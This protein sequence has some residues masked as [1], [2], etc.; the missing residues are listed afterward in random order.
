MLEMV[1]VLTQRETIELDS[2]KLVDLYRQLGDAAAEDV[3]CRAMEELALRLAHTE[4]LYRRHQRQE[5]RKSARLIVAIAEQVGMQLLAK[6]AIDVTVCIDHGDEAALAAVLSRLV[7]IG[8]RSLTEV[9]D[10]QD[11]SI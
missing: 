8:E 9:W 3:V 4:K 2:E 7:R 11:L 6:V 10:L 5:M 1:A